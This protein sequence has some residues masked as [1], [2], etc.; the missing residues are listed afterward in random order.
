MIARRGHEF[1]PIVDCIN[2]TIEDVRRDWLDRSAAKMI[3][4]RT[5]GLH[6]CGLWEVNEGNKFLK[7]K[8]YNWIR[9]LYVPTKHAGMFPPKVK[10]MLN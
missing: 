8:F 5:S 10:E 4:H 6:V 1:L 7:E 9:K 3:I 2:M